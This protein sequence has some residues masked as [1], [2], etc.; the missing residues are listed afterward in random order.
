MIGSDDS[1]EPCSGAIVLLNT[2]AHSFVQFREVGRNAEAA[3]C[4]SSGESSFM[5]SQGRVIRESWGLVALR[6]GPQS[7]RR[8][9][10][11]GRLPP[12]HVCSL[13]LVERSRFFFPGEMYFHLIENTRANRSRSLWA[14]K[15]H[16]CV[17]PREG[18]RLHRGPLSS[19][20]TSCTN[21]ISLK[22]TVAGRVGRKVELLK[23]C[24]QHLRAPESGL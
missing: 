20:Y 15:K 12:P 7:L 22:A 14:Q 21:P 18:V 19:N 2:I 8:T 5:L 9:H 4:A 10:T 24:S 23:L 3:L 17:K 13:L 11:G 6:A 1:H 16:L